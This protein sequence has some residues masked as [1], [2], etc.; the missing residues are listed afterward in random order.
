MVLLATPFVG[1]K[2]KMLS[3]NLSYPWTVNNQKKHGEIK[4]EVQ[5]CKGNDS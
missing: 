5:I 1:Q 2:R 3:R 4:Y